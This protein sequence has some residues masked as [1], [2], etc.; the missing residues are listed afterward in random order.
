MARP[1]QP[2]M[3]RW[4]IDHHHGWLTVTDGDAIATIHPWAVAILVKVHGSLFCPTLHSLRPSAQARPQGCRAEVPGALRRGVRGVRHGGRAPRMTLTLNYELFEG[5]PTAVSSIASSS[6]GVTFRRTPPGPSGA[7]ALGP[8]PWHTLRRVGPLAGHGSCSGMR[9]RLLPA[10]AHAPACGAGS[11]GLAFAHA[12]A[13]GAV[14]R[15]WLTTSRE[16]LLGPA[17]A[18]APACG[19]ARPCACARPHGGPGPLGPG[20]S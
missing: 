20:H 3:G 18:R 1:E 9:G 10:M 19:A 6:W 4:S 8:G 7:P 17:I 16:G 2:P 5:G 15:P 14:P 11:R 13:C 12:P